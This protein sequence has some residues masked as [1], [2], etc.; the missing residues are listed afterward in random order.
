[1]AGRSLPASAIALPTGG[2][3]VATAV[4]VSANDP[5]N[6]LGDYCQVRGS[7]QPVDASAQA[8]QF[9]VN[10]PLAWNGKTI[11][12]GGGGFNGRLIDGTEP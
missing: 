2:A 12:F 4:A 1:M 8:I 10:L 11:Q 3:T 5:A 7:I 9:A 6:T